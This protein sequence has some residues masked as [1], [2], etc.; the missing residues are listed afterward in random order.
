MQRE[1]LGW[2]EFSRGC[3]ALVVFVSHSF[4]A[5]VPSRY[6]DIFLW[7]RWGVCFFFVLS[8]FII[9]HAHW[10]DLNAPSRAPNFYW[11]RFVRIFPTYWLAL[12]IFLFV[13]NV[14][15]NSDHRIQIGIFEIVGNIAIW[16]TIQELLLSMAWTLRH[17]LLFY[18]LFSILILSTRLGVAVFACW[19][20]LLLWSLL[21]STPCEMLTVAADRCMQ[22][23]SML[24]P[25]DPASLI[26]TLN[27]NL[28]FFVGV[29]LAA[30]LRAGRI[31]P[32]L[33]VTMIG[34]A[35]SFIAYQVFD[36][37]YILA[38]LQAFV[39]VFCVTGAIAA[40]ERYRAPR[41]AHWFG[42]ISYPFYLL[43]VTA[44]LVAHGL[45]KRAPIELPW[46]STVLFALV[47]SLLASHAVAFLFE[48]RVRIFAA[49]F[50][51]LQTAS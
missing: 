39:I 31:N 45:L 50:R 30:C 12:V 48:N 5:D 23:N 34:T 46:Q 47:L 29:G 25:R 10:A 19:L 22:L 13:R 8:G 40:S 3:A 24:P 26:V 51:P 20:S 35:V 21:R 27:V 32:A 14:L 44:M 6:S 37:V 2:V 33:V 42:A 1:K 36:T 41:L 43:H 38:L 11:R 4:Y 18:G 9:A 49:R 16:P 7:G 17:E 15:G 28:Y